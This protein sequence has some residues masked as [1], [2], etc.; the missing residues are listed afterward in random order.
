MRHFFQTS[1]EGLEKSRLPH[2]ARIASHA[3][4]KAALDESEEEVNA[5]QVEL[6]RPQME[7]G[8]TAAVQLCV[9]I[10]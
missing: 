7:A 8:A 3:G 10:L 4:V 6:G 9:G 2:E 1:E 5:I